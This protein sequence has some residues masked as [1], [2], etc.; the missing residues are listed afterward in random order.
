MPKRL[1]VLGSGEDG[2]EGGLPTGT[3]D[4]GEELLEAA[5]AAT[6]RALSLWPLWPWPWGDAAEAS[7]IRTVGRRASRSGGAADDEDARRIAA[8]AV[9]EPRPAASA[10]MF[11]GGSGREVREDGFTGFNRVGA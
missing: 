3:E 9:A 5:G 1:G 11:R 4:D 7:T 2:G 6:P 10:C 8:A